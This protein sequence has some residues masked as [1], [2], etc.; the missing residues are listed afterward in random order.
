M[1]ENIRLYYN[2]S[3]LYDKKDDQ[4]KAENILAKGLKIDHTD[5][6]LLYAL[7]YHYSKYNQPEKAKATLIKLVQLYPNNSQYNSFLAQYN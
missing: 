4:K 7:A 1:P 5:E 2:L 6:S 3:L